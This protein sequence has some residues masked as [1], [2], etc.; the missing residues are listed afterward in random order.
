MEENKND[1][2]TMTDEN[3][4][5]HRFEIILTVPYEEKNYVI[6]HPLD[7]YP[8]LDDD[9]CVIFE[10]QEG[11]G[12]MVT[13]VPENDDDILDTVYALYVEWATEQEQKGE[14]DDGD[15]DQ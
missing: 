7:A 4:K 14:G 6:M 9:T 8:G 11:E 1:I 5:E 10:M 15:D 13:L 3:G 2:V 12:D